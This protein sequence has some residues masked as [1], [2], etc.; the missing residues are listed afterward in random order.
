M[1]SE[2]LIAG[3]AVGA[4]AALILIPKTRRMLYNGLCSIT[5]SIKNIT[6]DATEMAEKGSNELYKL[7][8]KAK[9][10]ASVVK[11]SRQA[12]Q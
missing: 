1:K 2:K 10:A 12:W 6:S 11:E 4:I 9:D 8:G 7:A 5:D 3:I